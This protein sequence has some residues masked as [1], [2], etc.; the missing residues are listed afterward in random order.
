MTL[1]QQLRSLVG[2]T[3]SVDT[4]KMGTPRVAP[5]SEETL[6]LLLQTASRHAWRV[7]IEGAGSWIVGDTT[8]EVVVSTCQLDR[9]SYSSPA[10]L[11]AT[12]GAGMSWS[13]LRQHLADRGM[14]VALDPPGTGR[15]VGSVVATGTAAT[16]RGAYGNVRD[17]VLGLTLVTGDG[18]V[19][20]VG[21]IVVKNVAGLDLAK[22][23]TG[24]FGAFGVVTSVTFRLRAV[25]RADLTLLGTG[26][27]D[28][29]IQTT[30]EILTTGATPAALELL[31]P[32]AAGT[33]RWALAIRLAGS[34]ADVTAARDVIRGVAGVE[35]P[36]LPAGEAAQLWDSVLAGVIRHPTTIR[37]GALPSSIDHV[38]DLTTHYL[39]ESWTAVTSSVGIVRWSGTA[40]LDDLRR[41]RHAAAQEEIPLTLERA[42]WAIRAP[43]GHFGAYREGVGRLVTGLRET[44]DPAGIL[45]APMESE[46]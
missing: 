28:T 5:Q 23:A 20:R 44:F 29:L 25:P 12:V 40:T 6:A 18:R 14:W 33:P 27:R 38:L 4:D 8:A 34:N 46:S 9:L 19:L 2:S 43:F 22:L 24:S 13:M 32:P 1:L 15:T 11:V 3:A 35:L 37:L 41:M 31:S 26:T 36:D 21:G 45:I 16:L 17:H 10:D 7:R 39:S 30:R 42:P